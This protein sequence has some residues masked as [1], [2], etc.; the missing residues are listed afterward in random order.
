M[1]DVSGC[2]TDDFT[3]CVGAT[4]CYIDPRNEECK[5][6]PDLHSGRNIID[7]RGM[8]CSVLTLATGN[9]RDMGDVRSARSTT[10]TSRRSS[11][12]SSMARPATSWM[13][14]T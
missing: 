12:A 7:G 11:C 5:T 8:M 2:A 6:Y 9:N 10:S 14:R 4:A 13:R 1:A 3:K